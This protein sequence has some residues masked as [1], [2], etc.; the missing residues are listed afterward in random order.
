M[1]S[2]VAEDASTTE[3]LARIFQ[4]DPSWKQIE[5]L[6]YYSNYAIELRGNSQGHGQEAADCSEPIG[7]RCS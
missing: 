5:G 6:V 1:L 7:R 2:L 3:D 4:V